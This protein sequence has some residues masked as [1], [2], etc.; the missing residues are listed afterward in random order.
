MLPALSQCK[1][2]LPGLSRHYLYEHGEASQRC[3]GVPQIHRKIRSGS[4]TRCSHSQRQGRNR[5]FT[6]ICTEP[7]HTELFSDI[8]PVLDYLKK[9]LPEKDY[10]LVSSIIEQSF[11][12][13]LPDEK[14]PAVPLAQQ[15]TAREYQVAVLIKEGLS[16]KEIADQLFITKKA[17]DY[18]RANIRKKLNLSPGDNLQVYLEMNL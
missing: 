7:Y 16:S 3:R 11:F 5:S 15:L 4:C 17:V 14:P 18:H 13:L 9:R 6:G 10:G 8:R 12:P 1:D 2:T